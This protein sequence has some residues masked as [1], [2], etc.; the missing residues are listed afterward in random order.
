MA[1]Y[2]CHWDPNFWAFAWIPVPQKSLRREPK[3]LLKNHVPWRFGLLWDCVGWMLW[4]LWKNI[5]QVKS[6]G[7]N[8]Y[9]Y[10]HVCRRHRK[11]RCWHPSFEVLPCPGFSWCS[12]VPSHWPQA[13]MPAEDLAQLSNLLHVSTISAQNNFTVNTGTGI[14]CSWCMGS[15]VF[16]VH[17]WTLLA[18]TSHMEKGAEREMQ[19]GF[20]DT[21]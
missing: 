19:K 5:K 16:S 17:Q 10:L 20:S 13:L 21:K 1:A 8:A 2:E 3:P 6:K 9:V 11:R 14:W 7:T 18:T 15:P 4:F 12:A